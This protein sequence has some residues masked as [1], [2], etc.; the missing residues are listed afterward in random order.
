MQKLTL[1]CHVEVRA[2]VRLLGSAGPHA[3]R[4]K[5]PRLGPPEGP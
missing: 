1:R 5:I 3:E 2:K 4:M